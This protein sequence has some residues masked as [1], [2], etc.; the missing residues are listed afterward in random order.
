M[1]SRARNLAIFALKVAVAALLIGW[2]LRSKS[3]DV[4]ALRLLVQSPTLFAANLGAWFLGA[5]VLSTHRWRI[6]LRLANVRL[7]VWRATQFQAMALFFNVVVPG[8]VGGDVLKA[9]YVSRDA[10]SKDKPAILLVVLIERLLGLAGLIATAAVVT[11]VRLPFLLG[12]SQ[13]RAMVP[14]VGVLVLLFLLGPLVAIAVLR[15]WGDRIAG[16]V[17][18]GSKIARLIAQLLE[19]ANLA[20]HR[21]GLLVAGLLMS[22][23]MH[24]ISI[25]YFTLLTSML[26]TTP[27]D[28]GLVATVFPIGLL[29][30]VLPVS[31]AGMGV[32]H[33]VFEQL[34]QLVGLTGGAT[35]FNVFLIGQITPAVLGAIPYLILRS[36]S[37]VT[38]AQAAQAAEAERESA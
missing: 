35:I 3:L 32:G 19:A 31:P 16:I 21:P 1:R 15:R 36:R 14:T 38:A 17:G 22:M 11:L 28:Y 10:P 7:P 34:Y 25:A 13:T 23:A 12:N 24:A 27:A 30:I 26:T 9:L 4:G 20:A 29:S 6:L 5:V 33:V 2:L 8:N 37:G 18:S